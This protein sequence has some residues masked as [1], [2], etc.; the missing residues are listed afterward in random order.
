MK[1]TTL[2]KAARRIMLA[3]AVTATA[4]FAEQTAAKQET[5]SERPNAGAKSETLV[6]IE[7]RVERDGKKLAIPSCTTRFGEACE[8]KSATE[9]IY[10]TKYDIVVVETNGVHAAVVEPRDFTMREVGVIGKATPTLADDGKVDLDFNLEVVDEPEWKNYG[11][12]MTASDGSKVDF[13]MEQPL[14]KVLSVKQRLLLALG[15]T[16]TVK[17]SGLTIDV[18]AR[19]RTKGES[20]CKCANR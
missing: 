11:G 9:Y 14:F 7:M 19:L 3:A 4:T 20:C 13:P 18:T 16:T 5:A 12:T 1:T 10:P 15:E 8:C 2:V 17:E 6:E